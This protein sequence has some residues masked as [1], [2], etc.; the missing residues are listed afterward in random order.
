VGIGDALIASGE[1]RKLHLLN[2]HPSII[3]DR[4]SRPQWVD[5]WNGVP[6][7]MKRV[8]ARPVNEINRIVN[9]PGIR[10]YIVGKTPQKWHWRAFQP[11]PAEIIF[12]PAELA[13]AEPF[14]GAVMIEPN[15]KDI[16]HPNK[17]WL[18]ERWEQ[19]A[20]AVRK[21]GERTLQCGPSVDTRWLTH[22]NTVITP[23]FRQAAA[24]L[25]VARAFVGTDGGLMHAAAAVGTPAVIL[26]SEYTSPG[27][28]GY[29]SMVNL[30]HAGK[31]CGNRVE[32]PGC[33]AAMEA[34]SV[35]EVVTA[36]KGIL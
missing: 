12:T 27:I 9:G 14:R 19:V 28:V 18:P 11:T 2:G 4:R 25:S 22:V 24:V 15:T 8:D 30:R 17:A 36:L 7:I 21:L 31:A 23:T 13:F 29:P 20:H 26:W 10:P 35:A 16:G 5:V 34:I 1:A 33:R 3:T 6:Y 32:C